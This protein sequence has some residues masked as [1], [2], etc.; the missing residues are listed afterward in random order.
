MY[1]TSAFTSLSGGSVDNFSVYNV[2]FSVFY[3]TAMNEGWSKSICRCGPATNNAQNWQPD[4]LIKWSLSAA[5]ADKC[6]TWLPDELI[7]VYLSAAAKADINMQKS[8]CLMGWS[9]V[10]HLSL[11]QLTNVHKSWQPDERLIKWSI[12]RLRRQILH[13]TA[14]RWVGPVGPLVSCGS[15]Q[16]CINN[17]WV[18]QVVV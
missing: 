9:R 7:V 4:E 15:W 13:K 17:G 10:V 12:C 11:R 14:A 6:A 3:K 16:M 1:A 2:S 18:D 5:A 8:G